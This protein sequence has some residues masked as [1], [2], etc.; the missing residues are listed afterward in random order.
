[1]DPEGPFT[2]Y[3][4][5]CNFAFNNKLEDSINLLNSLIKDTPALI[6]GKFARF[7]KSA[8][9]CDR[10]NALKYITD[11]L[12]REAELLDYLPLYI[13]WG[14]A[15]IGEKM[16]QYTG[17]TEVSALAIHLIRFF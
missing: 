10:E 7:F 1:M 8:L 15:L 6:F 14:F 17:L 16:K 5:A 11:E 12:K 4:C 2:R 3:W 9:L 13:A